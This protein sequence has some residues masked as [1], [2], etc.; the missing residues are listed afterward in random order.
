MAY[1]GGRWPLCVVALLVIA[2][3][4][5]I[6]NEAERTRA[7]ELKPKCGTR[8]FVDYLSPFRAMR[9]AHPPPDGKLAFGPAGLSLAE[10]VFG[11]TV[12]GGQGGFG[13]ESVIRGTSDPTGH[14]GWRVSARL[15]LLKA[16]GG[17]RRIAERRQ[18]S[19]KSARALDGRQFSVQVNGPPALYRYVLEFRLDSG[20]LLARYSQYVRA[21]RRKPE[22]V[23][24]V[25]KSIYH[26]GDRVVTQLANAG[27]ETISYSEG[28]ALSVLEGTDW[29]PVLATAGSGK[30]RAGQLG[31]GMASRC[32]QLSI[33]SNLA[34]GQYRIE[35]SIYLLDL[36]RTQNVV[37]ELRI[38]P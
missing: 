31:P 8:A 27:T 29:V 23:V 19:I 20:A 13:Y 6:T 35:R 5:V 25:D 28:V 34:A 30:R 24:L 1:S 10:V 21:M 22:T 15:Q 36:K 14:L 26:P 32:E 3:L 9:P 16:N 37:R 33:P 38:E 11:Q 12:V 18:W 4:M 2:G 7:A 17:V